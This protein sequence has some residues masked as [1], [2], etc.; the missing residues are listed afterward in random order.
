[1]CLRFFF[2]YLI[3]SVKKKIN[4]IFFFLSFF[5]ENIFFIR[6]SARPCVEKSYYICQHRMPY[7][8]ETNRVKIYQRWNVTFPHGMA[9]EIEV[10]VDEVADLRR[11]NYQNNIL[12]YLINQF[13]QIECNAKTECNK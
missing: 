5:L 4:N 2:Y 1:M 7:V 11:Y 8:S 10:K 9:N 3:Y 12:I 6:W 13:F